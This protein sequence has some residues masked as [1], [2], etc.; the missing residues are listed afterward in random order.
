M[1]PSTDP[2]AGQA[3]TRASVE[4]YLHAAAAEQVRLESA[5][6]DAR[7]RTE[8]ARQAEDHLE[9]LDLGSDD[10]VRRHVAEVSDG[11]PPLAVDTAQHALAA[12][13]SSEGGRP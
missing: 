10:Q 11:L 13:G 4:R 8:A 12:T 3:Y 9:S 7:A 6:A 5:I 1:T 2:E